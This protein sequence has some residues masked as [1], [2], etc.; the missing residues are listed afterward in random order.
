MFSRAVGSLGAGFHVVP[1]DRAGL[2]IG[3]YAL[4]LT[5]HSRTLASKVCVIR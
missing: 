1:M 3:I 4:R 2:P 5:Q